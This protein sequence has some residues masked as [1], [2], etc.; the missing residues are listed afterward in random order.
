MA[1]IVL[2]LDI[3][4]DKLTYEQLEIVRT[5]LRR[6]FNGLVFLCVEQ[7][8]LVTDKGERIT[9]RDITIDGTIK[10]DSSHPDPEYL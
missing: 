7:A 2:A 3:Y 1:K 6:E 10:L 4:G 5:A 8:R 9:H